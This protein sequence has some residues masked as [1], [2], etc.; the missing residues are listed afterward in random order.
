[1]SEH[2]DPEHQPEEDEIEYVSRG[3][4]KRDVREM[5]E[6]GRQLVGVPKKVLQDFGLSQR[7]LDALME[8]KRLVPRALTRHLRYTAKVLID[9]NIDTASVKERLA[10]L[11]RPNQ[12]AIAD[13]HR[14]EQWR[15]RLL[16]GDD[17][18][19]H[20]II[21]RCPEADRQR[22][23]QLTRNARKEAEQSKSPKS[24]RVLFQLITETIKNA[25]T[26]GDAS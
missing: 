24:A 12:L 13:F 22:L 26:S 2:I 20:D 6:L 16:A 11:H 10:A 25:K 23:R 15:D 18:A 17:S 5:V 4:L 1:M 8:G 7:V 14:A 21:A 9:E 19:L 3:E